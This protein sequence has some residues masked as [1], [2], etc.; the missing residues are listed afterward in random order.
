MSCINN[1]YGFS[2]LSFWSFVE[3]LYWYIYTGTVYDFT[4][5]SFSANMRSSIPCF[6]YTTLARLISIFLQR[7]YSSFTLCYNSPTDLQIHCILIGLQHPHDRCFT[8]MNILKELPKN[9]ECGPDTYISVTGPSIK[10]CWVYTYLR[11][12]GFEKYLH[13][14]STCIPTIPVHWFFQWCFQVVH[15]QQI[16]GFSLPTYPQSSSRS[17][18]VGVGLTPGPATIDLSLNFKL[19]Y[20]FGVP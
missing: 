12:S 17:K 1:H 6:P 7:L 15:D 10:V 13:N 8:P 20:G 16:Q 19:F 2:P 14:V 5:V 4:N 9:Y 3:V 11:G 18:N